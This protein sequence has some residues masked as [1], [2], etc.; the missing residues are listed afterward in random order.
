METIAGSDAAVGW[1]YACTWRDRRQPK[2][3]SS[4]VTPVVAR[5]V[6]AQSTRE[7]PATIEPIPRS[8][9]TGK[10]ADKAAGASVAVVDVGAGTVWVSCAVAAGDHVERAA[11]AVPDLLVVRRFIDAPVVVD[12][13]ACPAQTQSQA[14]LQV[15]MSCIQVTAQSTRHVLAHVTD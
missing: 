2:P 13:V 10:L 7:R 4:A 9:H 1:R 14:P 15:N 3:A 11:S 5:V 12:T 8:C 6:L